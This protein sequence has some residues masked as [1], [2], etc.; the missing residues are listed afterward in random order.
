[1][2]KKI[3]IGSIISAL[4][5]SLP[6]TVMAS[7]GETN[8]DNDVAINNLATK[9]HPDIVFT[10]IIG[11]ITNL[12]KSGGWTPCYNFHI[13]RVITL[14]TW[15]PFFRVRNDMNARIVIPTFSGFIDESFI[16]GTSYTLFIYN[17]D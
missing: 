1:M 7:I 15:F 17:S 11:K 9:Y 2:N 16:F 8:H 10:L 4:I 3:L 6:S 14:S 13:E 5:L 12:T